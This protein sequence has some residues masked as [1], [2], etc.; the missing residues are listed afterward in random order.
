MNGG[1]PVWTL[2]DHL[3]ADLWVAIVWSRSPKDSLPR[4]FDHPGRAAMTAEA[5]AAGIA[6]LKA[7]YQQ[8]KRDRAERRKERG[9]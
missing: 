5:K 6:A 8:R 7:K 2:T 9:E 3:L 1:S 4:G